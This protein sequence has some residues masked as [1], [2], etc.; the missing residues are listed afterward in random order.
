M[1]NTDTEQV[2][3]LRKEDTGI[4]SETKMMHECMIA[5]SARGY[6]VFRTNVGKVR[7]HDGRW[8][9]T[10]LP[11][12]HSDLY[13]FRHDGKIFYV[14]TKVKPNRPTDE[15]ILFLHAMIQSGAYGGIAYSPDDAVGIAE[16]RPE[17]AKSIE[18]SYQRL[19]ERKRPER[20]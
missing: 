1:E 19:C 6:K 4:L 7:M 15:Q 3:I 18:Q 14:E 8:F 20:K 13:G 16:G 5:L 10:G 11:K 2:Q 17:Y 12:G 9:D